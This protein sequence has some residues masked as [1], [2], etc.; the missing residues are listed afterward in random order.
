[1]RPYDEHN[2]GKPFSGFGYEDDE[3]PTVSGVDARA[4]LAGATKEVKE[5]LEA[6]AQGK[7]VPD[8]KFLGIIS[9]PAAAGAVLKPAVNLVSGYASEFVQHNS[10]RLI[11]AF[12]HN[13]GLRTPQHKIIAKQTLGLVSGASTLLAT[14]AGAM[15]KG[16]NTYKRKLQDAAKDIAPVLDD[17]KGGH[18]FAQMLGVTRDQNEVVFVHR[19]RQGSLLS[20]EST[21][22]L[23]A[24]GAKA[25][26]LIT[27]LQNTA[28]DAG[29]SFDKLDFMKRW[30]PSLPGA[31]EHALRAPS[32]NSKEVATASLSALG[33][34]YQDSLRVA[35]E[36]ANARPT[37]LTMITELARALKDNPQASDFYVPGAHRE[38]PLAQY[39]ALTFKGHQEDMTKLDADC[40]HIRKSLDADLMRASQ[41]IAHA[42]QEG[43]LSPLMLVRLV[44]ERQVIKNNGRSIAN[45]KD[46][47]H[48]IAKLSGK[49]KNYA[50]V[51][52][53]EFFE[54]FSKQDMKEALGKLEGVERQLLIAS[55]PRQIALGLGVSEAEYD[56]SQEVAGSSH[57]DTL[58]HVVAGLGVQ[59][60]EKLKQAGFGD[61]DIAEIQEAADAIARDGARALGKFT[62]AVSSVQRKV[63][64]DAVAG[65][66]HSL[67]EL[68]D[69]GRRALAREARDN[70]R[71]PAGFAELVEEQREQ[72]SAERSLHS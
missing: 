68:A 72:G 32:F 44:G 31:D 52:E 10:G 24:S 11:D 48:A 56:K 20:I 4:E 57:K 3:T 18:G 58:A 63:V 34:M 33:E 47:E 9:M 5:I 50:Q 15:W 41:Q 21:N 8:Y 37:A 46:V 28:R 14:E 59:G 71:R 45:K 53:K 55:A 35:H 49:V 19:K 54:G 36:Q 66:T 22:T 16:L 43:N 61:E 23:I 25:P 26:L 69:T 12:G 64:D 27:L 42:I 1:M 2:H 60:A 13:A 29:I 30:K 67:R 51:D 62:G 65:K 70:A 38:V 40:V 7:K 6:Q 39:I 17:I